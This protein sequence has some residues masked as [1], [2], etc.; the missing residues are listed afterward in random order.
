MA[1]L[2]ADR[3]D[4]TFGGIEVPDHEICAVSAVAD[5]PQ[6]SVRSQIYVVQKAVSWKLLLKHFVAA[7]CILGRS[8]RMILR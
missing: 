4:D 8:V 3:T 6:C 7:G 2:G 5:G 1:T